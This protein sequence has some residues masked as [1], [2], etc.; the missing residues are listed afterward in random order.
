MCGL[1]ASQWGEK[2]LSKQ[3]ITAWFFEGGNVSIPRHLLGLMEPLGLTFE[4]LGKILYLLYCGADQIKRSD[5]YATEAART[6]HS[7]GLIHWFTDT[8]T[9]DFSPMFDKISDNL[10]EQPKYMAEDSEDYTTADI[11]YAQ[12]VKKLEQKLGLFLSLRDKQSI[13]ETVQRYNWSYELVYHIYE[14]YYKQFRKYYDFRFF[15]QM[16]YGAQVQELE[17]FQKFTENLN[18]ITYKTTEVLRKLGKR[19]Y[20]SEPQKEMYLKWTAQWKFT[21][22]MI[23]LAVDETTGADNPSLDYMDK[24]LSSWLEKNILTPEDLAQEKQKREAEK[25]RTSSMKKQKPTI[26]KKYESDDVDLSFLE[27]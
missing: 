25:Q 14:I 10:G 4:D 3:N 2:T 9:V 1:L 8:D 26:S 17:S 6:L 18:T 15:C 13:Q 19:N 20:P 23:L 5:R 22:E 12:L 11:N 24:V 21:H 16:A 27:E 7:K